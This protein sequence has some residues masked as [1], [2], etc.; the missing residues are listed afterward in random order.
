MKRIILFLALI[1]N[2]T[3]FSQISN[4]VKW[5]TSVKKISATEYDLIATA[6][7]SSK[8]HL[9]SQSVPK[10]GPIATKFVFASNANYLKKGNTKQE[11]G[12]TVNDPIFDMKITYFDDTDTLLVY[13]NNNEIVETKDLNDSTLIELD[14]NGNIVS[15]TIEHAKEQTEV[16]SFSFN[17]VDKIA[18]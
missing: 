11:A 16:S 18:V 2:L 3:V 10:N 9:Y 15:M 4:P 12:H 1:V 8:W 5:S 17:K 13:F 6:T 14:Q 7:I